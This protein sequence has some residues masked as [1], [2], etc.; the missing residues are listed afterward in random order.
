MRGHDVEEGDLVHALGIVERHAVR[1]PRAAIVT[2]HVVFAESERRH[3]FGLVLSHRPE[4]IAAV[5][6]AAVRLRAVAVAA[7]IGRH[8]GEI[9]RQSRRDL[10]PHH[11][12]ERIAVQEQKRRP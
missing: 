4:R 5:V 9:L 2:A 10:V 7:Q 12:G 8:D 6:R 11:V 1:H 3:D